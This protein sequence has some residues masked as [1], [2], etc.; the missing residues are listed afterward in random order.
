MSALIQHLDVLYP[1]ARV[2]SGPDE[3]ELLLQR[4][5]ERAAKVPPEDR[6]EDRHA[7]LSGLVIDTL[8]GPLLPGTSPGERHDP[9]SFSEDP[10]RRAVARQTAERALPV[11]FAAC[12]IHERFLLA[13]DVLG[14]PSDEGLAAA[15][16]TSVEEARSM[17]DDAWASLRAA[18]RDVLTGPER[19]LVDVALPAEALKTTLRNLLTDYFQPVPLTL[20]SKVNAA[21]EKAQARREKDETTSGPRRVL[22]SLI[23]KMPSGRTVRR[24]LLALIVLV[25]LAAGGLGLFSL[26]QPGSE[27]PPSDL[28]ALTARHASTIRPQLNSSDP[29]EIESYVQSTWNRRVSVPTIDKASLQG[30]GHFQLN[31]EVEIPVFLYADAAE[32][33]RIAAFAYSYA[34]LDRLDPQTRLDTTLRTQLSEKQQFVTR[35]RDGRGMVLWRHRDDIYIAVASSLDPAE[36]QRR[37][38]P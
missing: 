2:L 1:L 8:D 35:Q 7:W 11:A 21:L 33:S 28:V 29:S 17:R 34:L 23:S 36:L 20:R 25:V 12:S 6:P 16:N 4:V 5:Y 9:S 31:D 37:I 27:S 24:S 10:F 15:L 13:L 19:M 30:V 18:L 38:Q 26:V 22:G 14:T 3:A 32:G